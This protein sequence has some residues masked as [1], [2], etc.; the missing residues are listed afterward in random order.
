MPFIRVRG[1]TPGDPLHEYDVTVGEVEK[2]PELYDV[3]DKKPVARSRPVVFV[4][5]TV[6]TPRPAKKRA[7]K[8][9]GEK[10]TTAP[11]GADS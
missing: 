11:T 9:T 1:K 6:K 10:T 8:S 5:G 4:S 2:H 7:A 3:L